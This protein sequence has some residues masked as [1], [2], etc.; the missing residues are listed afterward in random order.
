MAGYLIIKNSTRYG[1]PR[2][3]MWDILFCILISG[4]I[5]ARML[6]VLV[7]FPCY[8]KKLLET[9]FLHKGGLAVQGGIALALIAIIIFILIKKL[10]LWKT[11][12]LIALYLPMGQA[13]GRIGCLL[14]GCCYGKTTDSLLG[15]YFTRKILRGAPRHPTQLY[16]SVLLLIVFII[17]R[18]LSAKERRFDGEILFFYFFMY[19]FVRFS[20]DFFRGDL[21]AVFLGLTASQLINIAIFVVSL[22]VYYVKSRKENHIKSRG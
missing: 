19:T 17:L 15:I 9:L 18:R 4:L 8:K 5:G 11:L 13:I 7:N 14:N 2:E 12:D 1:V 10:P 21:H 22:L 16:L 3:D 6:H 20:V